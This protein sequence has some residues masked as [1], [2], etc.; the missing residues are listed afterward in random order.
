MLKL[1]YMQQND[2]TDLWL[3]LTL[4]H[5][6]LLVKLDRISGTHLEHLG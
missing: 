1:K 4:V 6:V 5:S 3:L 2:T